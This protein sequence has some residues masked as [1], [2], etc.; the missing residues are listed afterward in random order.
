MANRIS[1]YNRDFSESL[2]QRHYGKLFCVSIDK[3]IRSL[4]RRNT[5]NA[6]RMENIL[7]TMSAV[8]VL[9]LVAVA[10]LGQA[11]PTGTAAP[12]SGAPA[13]KLNPYTTPDKSASVG[14]PPGWNVTK[15]EFGV[16]QMSGPKGEAISM[17][18]GVYVQDGPFQAGQKAN[19][20]IAMKMPLSA[21][22]Q[23]KYV[24]LWQQA[25]AVIGGPDPHVVILS[26][27]P[28][29]L[30][31]IGQCGV[32]LGTQTNTQGPQKFETRFCSLAADTNGFYKLFWMNANIPADLAT[33][34]RAT[35]EAV[36]SSY[37]PSI[38]SLKLILK[39]MTPPMPPPSAGPGISSTMWGERM[40]DQSATCMDLGVIR[41]EPEWKL[42]SYCN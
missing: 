1:H 35:A 18:N 30:G 42:P 22:I 29:S 2:V 8:A 41:E 17:G 23:Q 6:M 38:D 39:P 36:L 7:R 4:P 19:G 10:V 28:I 33:Q 26:A 14:V 11:A 34:E 40:S 31:R 24:M 12:A 37:K 3:S 9:C 16:I 20:L 13:V 5:V 21:T 25:A 15:G 27:A 32:F